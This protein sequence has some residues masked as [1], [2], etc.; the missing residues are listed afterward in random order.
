MRDMQGDEGL[1]V[2][3]KARGFPPEVINAVVARRMSATAM[4][5]PDG[6]F[7]GEGDKRGVSPAARPKATTPTTPA[8]APAPV[9][10]P[11]GMGSATRPRPGTTTA[12][13]R[14]QTPP[15]PTDSMPPGRGN[16]RPPPKV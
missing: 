13:T 3:L 1:R 9:V 8:P 12:G 4:M 7:A 14:V 11:S 6:M 15:A 2:F 16:R 10:V 5:G